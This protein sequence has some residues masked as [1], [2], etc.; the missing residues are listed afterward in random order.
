[1]PRLARL[2]NE[3]RVLAEEFLLS[4]GNLKDLA[5]AKGVSYPT[6]RKQVDKMIEQIKTL[7]AEDEKKIEDIISDIEQGKRTGEEGL[8]LIKEINGE[9]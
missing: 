8:R 3:L 6:L 7:K 4:G 9:L 5:A 2:D 1:M